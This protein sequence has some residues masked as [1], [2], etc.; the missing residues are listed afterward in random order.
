M[1]QAPAQL[2]HGPHNATST[3]RCL[4]HSSAP[5]PDLPTGW[6]RQSSFPQGAT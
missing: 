5:Q 4:H 2:V 3:A 6:E 1:Q